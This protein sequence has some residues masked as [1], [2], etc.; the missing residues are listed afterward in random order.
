MNAFWSALNTRFKSPTDEYDAVQT[1]DSIRMGNKPAADFFAE[2]EDLATRAGMSANN[3]KD[4][5]YMLKKLQ[6]ALNPTVLQM[7]YASGTIPTTYATWKAR[8]IDVAKQS[9][10]C[11]IF[12]SAAAIPARHTAVASGKPATRL[13]CRQHVAAASCK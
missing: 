10:P 4:T 3:G 2:W 1:L 11:R 13:S 5:A 6:V 9:R 7:I 8:V 12:T